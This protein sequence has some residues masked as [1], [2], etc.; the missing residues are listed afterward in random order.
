MNPLRT[1][2]KN[3]RIV[4]LESNSISTA[5]REPL[6]LTAPLRCR[7]R[8]SRRAGPTQ[9]LSKNPLRERD[10]RPLGSTGCIEQFAQLRGEN[11]SQLRVTAP[12]Q[13]STLNNS[14]NNDTSEPLAVKHSADTT[15]REQEISGQMGSSFVTPKLRSRVHGCLLKC[16]SEESVEVSA[17]LLARHTYCSLETSDHKSPARWQRHDARLND[18]PQSP[19]HLIACS[20]PR[21]LPFSN[22]QSRPCRHL[23]GAGQHR[24]NQDIV[25][26]FA[27][28]L[29]SSC[30]SLTPG[31]SAISAEHTI[32]C[33]RRGRSDSDLRAAL[34]TTARKD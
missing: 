22:N 8:P 19:L 31:Y 14:G 4:K 34:A 1:P 18:M 15:S 5:N 2:Y 24:D 7:G 16:R 23:S 6:T 33:R 13:Q 10:S 21:Y 25:P 26:G 3:A 27:P 17:K 9:V 29:Q 20:G 12:L 28:L 30:E 32:N 11:L